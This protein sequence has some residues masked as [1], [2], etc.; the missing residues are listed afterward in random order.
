M[1]T[2]EVSNSTIKIANAALNEIGIEPITSFLDGSKKARTINAMFADVLEEALV[3]YPWRF[4]RATIILQRL[5]ATPPPEWEGVYALPKSA[6]IIQK[7]YVNG[8]EAPFD[9]NRDGVLVHVSEGSAEIVK[10]DVTNYIAPDQWPSYFRRAFV[11]WLASAICMPLTQDEQLKQYLTSEAVART[12]LAQSRE[13]QSRT[14][15]RIDTKMFIR[16]RR[17]GRRS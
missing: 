13:S 12:K 4:A 16:N 15:P 10:A 11:F 1:S 6:L 2:L 5:S 9:R 17:S 3:M 8:S 14:P 7:V